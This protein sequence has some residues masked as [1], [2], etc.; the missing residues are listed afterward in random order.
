MKKLIC[1]V[2]MALMMFSM[3]AMETVTA[4][5]DLPPGREPILKLVLDLFQR[6][7]ASFAEA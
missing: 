4:A 1:L 6:Q 2:S 3:L 7:P 5:P